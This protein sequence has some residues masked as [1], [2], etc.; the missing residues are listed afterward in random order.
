[1]V[2]GGLKA[3]TFYVHVAQHQHPV[4]LEQ[5]P[6]VSHLLLAEFSVP[7]RMI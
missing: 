7:S 6:V 4:S 1:M 3:F 5:L 2:H